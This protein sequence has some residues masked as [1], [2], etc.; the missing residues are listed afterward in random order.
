MGS[1]LA[2]VQFCLCK[3][4]QGSINDLFKGGKTSLRWSG[5]YL[6]FCF[7]PSSPVL[8]C[9]KLALGALTP[10]PSGEIL[11]LGRNLEESGIW[12]LPHSSRLKRAEAQEVFAPFPMKTSAASD[13]C[14]ERELAQSVIFWVK[15]RLGAVLSF[16]NIITLFYFF[17]VYKRL[18]LY[19]F[20]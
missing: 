2:L 4:T 10:V 16:C 19:F 8:G 18:T 9:L 17:A 14:P 1:S 5:F 15:E 3:I 6:L 13:W 7:G 12:T 20:Y 11:G